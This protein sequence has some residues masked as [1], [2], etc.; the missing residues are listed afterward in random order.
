M[1][2]HEHQGNKEERGKGGDAKAAN[3]GSCQRR[4]LFSTLAQTK[5]HR[6]H[7]DD[8][9]KGRHHDGTQ[10]RMTRGH[11]RIKR[12]HASGPKII[13]ESN[14]KNRIGG[15]HADRHNGAHQAWHIEGGLGEEE[16]PHN[17][18]E[19]SRERADDDEW[20][21]P[22]LIVDDHQEV[23]QQ[24]GEC[25][26]ESQ[27]VECLIHAFHLST[28]HDLGSGRKILALFPHDT[29]HLCRH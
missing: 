8:H 13:G 2:Q 6:E 22:A 23:D 10:S 18:G 27:T 25:K 11:H 7:A 5:S 9:G 29:I 26:T 12:S 3:H 28:H 4:I 24:R 15:R 19:G 20:I 21:E 17:A 1:N 14:Q 16:R